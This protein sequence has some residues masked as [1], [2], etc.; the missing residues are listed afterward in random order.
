MTGLKY[1]ELKRNIGNAVDS[2]PQQYYV[3]L[4]NGVYKREGVYKKQRRTRKKKHKK[5]LD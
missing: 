1:D 2:I 4:F 5:Y 3:N